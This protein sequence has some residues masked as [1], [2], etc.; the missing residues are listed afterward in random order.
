LQ[1]D[2]R[3]VVAGSMH[4]DGTQGYYFAIARLFDNGAFDPS[5]GGGGQSYGDMSTQAPNVLSDYPTSM[6]I[7]GG[8][9]IVGGSTSVNGGETRFS[10]TKTR[11]DLLLAADFE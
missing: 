6:V 5:Y 8:G 11:T 4:R 7:V 1:S 10:V 3:I 9:I 2:A